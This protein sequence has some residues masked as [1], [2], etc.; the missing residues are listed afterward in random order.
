MVYGYASS[1]TVDSHGER[2]TKQA[3]EAALPR[4]LKF[5]NI[6]EMHQPSAVGV[7]RQAEVD[8]KGLYIGA[9]IVDDVAW[10]KVVGGVYKGFSIGGRVGARSPDDPNV[11]TALQLSE[12]SLVDRPANPDAVFDLWK[13]GEVEADAEASAPTDVAGE[14]KR[15]AGALVQLE[16]RLAELVERVTALEGTTMRPKAALMAVPKEADDLRKGNDLEREPKTSLDAIKLALKMP[17]TIF[18]TS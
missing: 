2:V 8:D 4:Y 6:R 15:L 7:A 14:V 12:I 18:R 1:E 3:L 9:H 13:A 10:R 16:S 5:A 11:I 17:Q